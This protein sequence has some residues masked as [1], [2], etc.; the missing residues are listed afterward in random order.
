MGVSMK[1][2]SS[3]RSAP[4]GPEQTG[5]MSPRGAGY[6]PP[7]MRRPSGKLGRHKVSIDWTTV[8]ICLNAAQ[9]SSALLRSACTAPQAQQTA[10]W[11]CSHA[12]SLRKA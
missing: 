12:A 11:A 10:K 1:A 3:K 4:K 2:Q 6:G 9:L 8:R 7:E 5:A